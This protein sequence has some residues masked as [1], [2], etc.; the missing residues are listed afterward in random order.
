MFL[1]AK[2]T[3]NHAALN[4]TEP[5]LALEISVQDVRMALQNCGALIPE[6]PMV[7]QEFDG[8]EDT[9]G[10]D[11]FLA[12]VQ[13]PGNKDIRRVALEGDSEKQDYL[14]ALKKKHNTT[15]EGDT[16][17]N[18]TILGK[19]AE[20]RAVKVEGGDISSVKEWAERLKRP[21]K[22]TSNLSSRRASSALSSLGDDMDDIEF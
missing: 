18:G 13:G 17:Y 21:R 14:T 1:L 8:E 19:P 3:A 20:P 12:W 22:D 2:A 15:T 11:A 5:E 16:R 9:R 7:E 6:K 4:H 10:M